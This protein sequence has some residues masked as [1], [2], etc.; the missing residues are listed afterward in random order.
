MLAALRD[1]RHMDKDVPV[2]G[3][4][5]RG[6]RTAFGR[7]WVRGEDRRRFADNSWWDQAKLSVSVRVAVLLHVRSDA[8][9]GDDSPAG[10]RLLEQ[11][12]VGFVLIG[13]RIREFDECVVKIL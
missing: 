8:G 12:V 5:P 13:V 2:R 1:G 7:G 3:Q 11:A 10:G 4:S 9:V 6:S